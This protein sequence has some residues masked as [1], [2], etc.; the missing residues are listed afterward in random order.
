MK[1]KTDNIGTVSVAK[2]PTDNKQTVETKK[3]VCLKNNVINELTI[4]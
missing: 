4:K 1:L 3:Y 2:V